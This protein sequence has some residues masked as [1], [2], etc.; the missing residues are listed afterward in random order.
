ML[1]SSELIVNRILIVSIVVMIIIII[2]IIFQSKFSCLL[3]IQRN[4][5][6]SA[7][8]DSFLSEINCK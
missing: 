7:W 6:N 8:T 5:V 2:I 4:I 3:L 1:F